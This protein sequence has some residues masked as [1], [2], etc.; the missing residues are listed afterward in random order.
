MNDLLFLF[1]G[2]EN[3]TCNPSTKSTLGNATFLTVAA[4][5]YG[6]GVTN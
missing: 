3:K 2:M 4:F 5:E 6:R 1:T